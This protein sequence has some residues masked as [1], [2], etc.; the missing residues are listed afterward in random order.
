MLEGNYLF[1]DEPDWE[2]LSHSWDYTIFLETDLATIERR[3]M[4]RWLFHGYTTT[5][6]MQKSALMTYPMQTGFFTLHALPADLVI[7]NE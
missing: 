1:L 4:D 7:K 3:L 2:E 6:L 5:P